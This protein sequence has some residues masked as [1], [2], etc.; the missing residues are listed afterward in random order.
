MVGIVGSTNVDIVLKVENF[1][2]P[3]Q[4]QRALSLEKFPG[5][6]GANQ[7]VTVAKLSKKETVFITLVGDDEDGRWMIERFES[8]G[9]TGPRI[10]GRSTGKAFI[11]VTSSGENRIIIHGGANDLLTPEKVDW[12]LLERV[13]V[14][15]LQNE[16]PF[17][18]TF[19]VAKFSKKRGKTVV[20]D[21]AP[22]GGVSEKI[23]EYVDVLTPNETEL[24]ELAEN[25]FGSFDGMERCVEKFLKFGVGS[26]V[27]KLG[28]RG[29]YYS[30]GL[31]E[32]MIPAPRVKAVDTT[33]AG[34]VF[35]G[36]FAYKLDSGASVLESLRFAV[37]SAS[38]SV[39]RMGAQTSIPDPEEVIE[40]ERGISEH[41]D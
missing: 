28:E 30:N 16:I 23:L 9:I 18:T 7:A 39:T 41:E 13:G 11:E 2:L 21:P 15:L 24:R 19:E 35:N 12:D 32:V 22:A 36:A 37:L 31:K 34:D 10:E 8:L 26:V 3:G 27:V 17:E 1:T 4:T 14:V 33:A 29:V 38:L 40:F 25:F 5:G 20:F 6:K